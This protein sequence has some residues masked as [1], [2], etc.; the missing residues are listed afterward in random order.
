MRE[1]PAVQTAKAITAQ[2]LGLPVGS[3]IDVAF[4]MLIDKPAGTDKATPWHQDYASSKLPMAPIGKKI[5]ENASL[6][7]WVAL[8]D[9]DLANGCMHFLP[10]LHT[11]PLLPHSIVGGDPKDHSRLLALDHVDTTQAVVCPLTAGGCTIHHSGT[12]HYT[13]PNLTR[14][15][16]R[17]AYIFSVKRYEPETRLDRIKKLPKSWI[18][19]TT[20]VWLPVMLLCCS[21]LARWLFP[22]TGGAPG[23]VY[24]GVWSYPFACAIAAFLLFRFSRFSK[25]LTRCTIIANLAAI[26]LWGL[27]LYLYR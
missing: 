19:A 17:R 20:F 12:P 8:D 4:D 27:A 14:D 9:V 25:A 24:L 7:F 10:G 18:A 2:L 6:T 15:R 26:P 1:N 22:Q 5:P 16:N 3:R 13:G 21:G 23:L 11:G